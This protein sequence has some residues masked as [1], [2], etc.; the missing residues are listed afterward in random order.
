MTVAILEPVNGAPMLALWHRSTVLEPRPN[1]WPRFSHNGYLSSG[2]AENCAVCRRPKACVSPRK[3]KSL[4]EAPVFAGARR[5]AVVMHVGG[6]HLLMY[7]PPENKRNLMGGRRFT[8]V[9]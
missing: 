2:M 9:C 6:T 8:V 5:S 1:I 7:N 4:Q 3:V